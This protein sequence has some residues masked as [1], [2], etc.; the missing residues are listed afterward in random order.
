VSLLADTLVSTEVRQALYER[1]FTCSTDTPQTLVKKASQLQCAVAATEQLGYRDFTF[2]DLS[3]DCSLYK[4]KPLLY[5]LHL[6]G[7]ISHF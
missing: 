1:V 5:T 3:K 4:H 6:E 2:D 7:Y